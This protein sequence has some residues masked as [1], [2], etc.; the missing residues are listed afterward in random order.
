[1]DLVGPGLGLHVN[2]DPGRTADGR[3][4]TIGDDLKLGDGVRAKAGLAEACV[5]RV[6]RHLKTIQID[7]EFA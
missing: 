4:K 3:V 2:V 7:L 5:G 6:L 1:V